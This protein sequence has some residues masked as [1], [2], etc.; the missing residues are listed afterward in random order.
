[1]RNL[2][3]AIC[4]VAGPV[5]GAERSPWAL[6][7]PLPPDDQVAVQEA[8]EVFRQTMATAMADVMAAL[9][10]D[11]REQLKTYRPPPTVYVRPAPGYDF[12]LPPYGYIY[13]YRRYRY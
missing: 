9:P 7:P 11:L 12:S 10:L 6:T 13:P 8:G 4:M 3:F 1:M 5:F 2:V